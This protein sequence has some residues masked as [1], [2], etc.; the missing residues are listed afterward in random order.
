[1]GRTLIPRLLIYQLVVIF[2]INLG[3]IYSR[4]P[5]HDPQFMAR[6]RLLA[7]HDP[8]SGQQLNL[9]IDPTTKLE[10]QLIALENLQVLDI[11]YIDVSALPPEIG[12]LINLQMLYLYNTPIS[13]LPPEINALRNLQILDFDK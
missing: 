3:A 7:W 6:L 4:P 12:N 13:K 2:V 5:Q 1:M 11:N 10:Q 9:R 8:V